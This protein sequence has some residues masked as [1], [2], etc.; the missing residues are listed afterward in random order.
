MR[1]GKVDR[2]TTVE[3]GARKKKK[4]IEDANKIGG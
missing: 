1:K 3:A 4:E 2:D